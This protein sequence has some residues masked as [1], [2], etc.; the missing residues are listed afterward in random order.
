[1]QEALDS[2]SSTK[3]KRGREGG[4]ERGKIREREE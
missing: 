3:K 4:R 2:I 1:M